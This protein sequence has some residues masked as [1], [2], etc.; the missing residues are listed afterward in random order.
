MNITVNVDE[1][2]L[3]T[4]V[5]KV[6]QYDED[7]DA[8]VKGERTVGHLVAE[9]IVDRLLKSREYPALQQR[10]TD[11]RAEVIRELIRP[12]LE[13]AIAKPIVKTNSY[14]EAV[15]EPTTLREVIVEEARKAVNAPVD[16]WNRERGTFLSQAVSAEVKK[17]LSA[18]IADA[19]K[20]AREL[21]SAEIG[22]RVADAVQAGLKAR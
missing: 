6:V 5:A 14:G 19:V 9:M 4:A 17:A 3:S 21:V 12:Q 2:S 8:M 10:V 16:N 1:V 11:I 13:E 15:G 22:Q 7:G 20:K 18:E